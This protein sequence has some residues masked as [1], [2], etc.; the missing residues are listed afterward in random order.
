LTNA[1]VLSASAPGYAPAGQSLISV[2]TLLA[3]LDER[4]VRHQL[5]DWFGPGVSDW[6]HLA[7]YDIADALPAG[8]PPLGRLR[9]PVR[10]E[11]G[12]YVCGD[13]RDSPSQQGALVS[14]RRA[15]DA[16]LRDQPG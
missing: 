12:L 13:H 11:P 1:V 16:L 2:S 3:D 9:R 4:T 15:A 7:R 5:T 14:G 10:V 8:D 6:R